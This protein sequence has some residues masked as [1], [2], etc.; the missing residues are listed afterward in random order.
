MVGL[1]K[2]GNFARFFEILLR[3]VRRSTSKVSK[4]WNHA[5]WHLL[6]S[7]AVI[8]HIPKCAGRSL[9]VLLKQNRPLNKHVKWL[10]HSRISQSKAFYFSPVLRRPRIVALTRNPAD[11]YLSRLRFVRQQMSI[12]GAA[13][14]LHSRHNLYAHL[15]DFGEA[16]FDEFIDNIFSPK[17]VNLDEEPNIDPSR[18]PLPVHQTL[19]W[20]SNTKRGL[21]S[22]TLLYYLLPGD[23]FELDSSEAVD[24]SLRQ[25]CENTLFVR[26][27]HLL[28]D[29]AKFLNIEN[30]T[31][32]EIG[33][34]SGFSK[35]GDAMKDAA[36]EKILIMDSTAAS[37]SGGY[38]LAV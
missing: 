24:D 31:L 13:S 12:S 6:P 29:A 10:G 33:K 35:A 26:S 22:F 1:N 14:G 5:V 18:I 9:N 38:R 16:S 17:W 32:E 3:L 21:Y 34:S 8:V 36:V 25:I 4:A 37:L 23:V 7:K 28:E 30:A 20:F 15:T 19:D 27:E 11:W 2:M